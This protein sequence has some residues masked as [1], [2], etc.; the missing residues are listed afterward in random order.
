FIATGMVEE[1]ENNYYLHG[2]EENFA[3]ILA[4]VRNGLKGGRPRK[5]AEIIEKP[6][7]QQESHRKATENLPSPTPT[8]KEKNTKKSS[9]TAS[10]TPNGTNDFSD[11]QSQDLFDSKLQE[12]SAKKNNQAIAKIR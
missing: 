7:T 4:N 9:A 5:D 10:P 12:N 2:S 6:I 3:W 8:Q 1:R 11:S